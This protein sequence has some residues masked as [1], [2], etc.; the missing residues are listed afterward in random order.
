[1]NSFHVV[2]SIARDSG[3]LGL[4]A[5]ELCNSL[6]RE[7]ESVTLYIINRSKEEM[8]CYNLRGAIN[9]LGDGTG[10]FSNLFALKKYLSQ[11]S[12]DIV[13]IHGTWLPILAVT[14]LFAKSLGIPIV[15]SP[16]G[17]LEPWALNHR[18][19]KKRLALI[20]YQQQIYRSA[21]L[22]VATA[23]QELKSI[24]ALNISVPV[25]VIP[26]GVDIPAKTSMADQLK[27]QI[28]FLSRVHPKKGLVDLVDAWAIVRN[29]SW[30][31]IIAGPDEGGHL[32]QVRAQIDSLGLS[33]D[34]EFIGFVT[35]GQKEILYAEADVFVLPTYSENF[36]I[37]IAEALVRG[38]PV[39][40]T[41][42]APWEDIQSWGCGW[43]V[44]PGV[45]TIA[46]ALFEAMNTSKAE[47]NNMG[48][49][50]IDLVKKK[51]TWDQIGRSALEAYQWILGQSQQRPEFV[52]IKN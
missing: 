31:I 41:T 29:P 39:I 18:G 9:I 27:K 5:L 26:N 44:K 52:D 15:I 3:G 47:L 35:G 32:K 50:G 46:Q 48:N 40:T 23:T 1:M 34:F 49:R 21:S 4:A 33:R 42:G 25:G 36:G 16:H 43:W 12:F 7:G 19:W 51:Y 38:V 13:H 8:R 14:C 28:L 22:M 20:F 6:I 11:N 37:A 45:N 17:S 24:R 30:K 2:P 10:F